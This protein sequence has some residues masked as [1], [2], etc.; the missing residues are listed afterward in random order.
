ML[1]GAFPVS[2][3]AAVESIEND[4]ARPL[5]TSWARAA[6]GAI[7]VATANMVRA[8]RRISV[9]RGYDPR[10]AVLVAYGG[11]GPLHAAAVARALGMRRVL[12]PASPGVFAALGMLASDMRYESQR[13]CF[14]RLAGSDPAAL[15]AEF[16]RVEGE[17]A[18]RAAASGLDA[19]EAT[20]ERAADLRYQ[21]QGYT[22]TV[23]CAGPPSAERL[24]AAFHSLHNEQYGYDDPSAV[25][26]LVNVRVALVWPCP[27][28]DEI[29]GSVPGADREGAAEP[30]ERLV[31]A[32]TDEP[33]PQP[34]YQRALLPA[35]STI[36]G[37]ALIEQYDSVIRLPEGAE[38]TVHEG[39]FVIDLVPAG[40]ARDAAPTPAEAE[41]R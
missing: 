40:A 4:L 38:G 3:E 1:G 36:S 14:A 21:G 31:W 18:E 10:D 16:A 27:L 33:I 8:V 20:T 5:G 25:I 19:A 39:L 23:P 13:T 17:L 32:D 29:G 24:G 37:P 41:I 34:V 9:E 35:G 6:S 15:E 22:L 7:E 2:R 12:I 11:A 26:E 28:D 30:A